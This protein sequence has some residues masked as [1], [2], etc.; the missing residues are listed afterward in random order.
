MAPDGMAVTLTTKALLGAASKSGTLLTLLKIMTMTKL[1][2][3]VISAILIVGITT[4]LVVHYRARLRLEQASSPLQT[5]QPVHSPQYYDQLHQ[6]AGGKEK[7]VKTLG[8]AFHMYASDHNDQFPTNLE[9]VSSYFGKGKL[10]LTGTNDIDLFYQGPLAE[11]GS[12]TDQ[13]KF[14]LFRD[15]QAWPGPDGKPTRVY[16]MADGSVQ[17]LES[18][19]NFKSWESAHSFRSSASN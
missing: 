2:V 6:M 11:L 12:N 17:T 3:G 7:D 8:L 18:D 16:G 15:R 1:K 10:S 13:G 9:A 5:S 4:P 19:D 14:I